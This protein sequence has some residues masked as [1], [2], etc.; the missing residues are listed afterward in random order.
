MVELIIGFVVGM[1]LP[2]IF[3]YFIPNDKFYSWGYALG[4]KMSAYGS[5]KLKK[6]DY[7][8]LENNITSSVVNFAAGF[9]E[10]AD[11]DDES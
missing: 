8:K 11:E 10:G 1:V 7:E 9:Q 2:L 6:E 3:A 5:S 4:K